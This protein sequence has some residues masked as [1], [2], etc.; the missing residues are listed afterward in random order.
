M[1]VGV[2]G[3][4]FGARVVAPVFDSTPG[5]DVV[6]VVSARDPLDVERLC[7]RNDLD[8]VSVHSPPFSHLPDVRLALAGGHHVL[9]DKPF[10][11]DAAEASL[12]LDGALDAGVVHL[13]NFEFRHDPARTLVRDLV[14]GGAVGTPEE[15]HWTH[16][17]SGS[18]AP[19]RPYGWLFD[20]AK[21]GGWVGAWAS[22]AVDTIRWM[23]GEI[24]DAGAVRRITV[25]RRPDRDGQVHEVTAED[26]VTAWLTTATG[27]RC[28]LDSTFAATA[29][30]EPCIVVSGSEG[31]IEC[32][33]DTR[34]TLRRLD[35]ESETMEVPGV[36]GSDRHLVPMQR[37]AEVV[38][39]AVDA[40]VPV[41]PTFAD[42]LACALV[43]DRLRAAPLS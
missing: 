14:A 28:V 36:D 9:C 7:R 20:R 40:G 24:V 32:A 38:R 13:L 3:T 29:G 16:L 27:V 8:L 21:G 34:I 12:M 35:G 23:F 10:G 5:C 31:V 37:W 43:V 25:P 4:G 11:L 1:R 41:G 26:G 2:I 19:L 17:S 30:V 6:E 22:H 15:F 42:G 39:D 33:G 18:R